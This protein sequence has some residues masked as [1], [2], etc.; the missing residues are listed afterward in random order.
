M[1]PQFPG[2]KQQAKPKGEK[3]HFKNELL[4]KRHAEK[5]NISLGAWN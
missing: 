5:L 1:G 4:F 2:A 3:E